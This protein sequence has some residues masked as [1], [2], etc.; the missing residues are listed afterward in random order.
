MKR[1]TLPL[2]IGLSCSLSGPALSQEETKPVIPSMSGQNPAI[3]VK[4]LYKGPLTQE[5]AEKLAQ[6]VTQTE[7]R[8]EQPTEPA[9]SNTET[10][11]DAY[12]RMF[13]QQAK[14]AETFLDKVAK[15]LNF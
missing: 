11:E 15:T 13:A 1:Y 2:L 6:T 7:K 8:E 4:P 12:K 10:V 9:L 14:P 5:Q 3:P